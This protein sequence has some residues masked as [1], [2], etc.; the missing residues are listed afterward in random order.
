MDL[1]DKLKAKIKMIHRIPPDDELDADTETMLDYF[2]KEII[3]FM[4]EHKDE[5]ES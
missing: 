2:A 5:L 1:R 4:T 3:E